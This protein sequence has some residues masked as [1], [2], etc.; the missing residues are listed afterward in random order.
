MNKP[1]KLNMD[2]IGKILYELQPWR[3]QD[4]NQFVNDSAV[5]IF[6]IYHGLR[7]WV[8]EIISEAYS[9]SLHI[10]PKWW[11]YLFIYSI[12]S[13][14]FS[15]IGFGSVWIIIT[16]FGLIFCN[17]GERKPGEVSA[18]SVF[19]DGCRR[20]L[21]TLTAEQFEKEIRHDNDFGY[22][23]NFEANVENLDEDV[24]NDRADDKNARKS[25]KSGKKARRNYEN[26][27]RRRLEAS[28]E[29]EREIDELEEW[30]ANERN[31]Q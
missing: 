3:L 20:I 10:S 8:L 25:R 16:L 2:I 19:N 22:D 14:L 7:P 18:Y 13:Y 28:L 15:F 4:F 12:F 30:E 6:Q 17:L 11:I 31:F 1:K 23:N 27:M 9:A 29:A 24:A 26:R 21:G 5:I